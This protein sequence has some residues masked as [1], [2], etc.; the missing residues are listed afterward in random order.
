MRELDA[1]REVAIAHFSGP[2]VKPWVGLVARG[3]RL[4]AQSVEQLLNESPHAFARRFPENPR[5]PSTGSERY[6]EQGVPSF[7]VS[8]VQEWAEQLRG[9]VRETQRERSVIFRARMA[10]QSLT[11]RVRLA[12]F[13]VFL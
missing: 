13:A 6:G 4:S 1:A 3:E 11:G 7:V 12:V 10:V 5:L 2:R 9:V 8:L